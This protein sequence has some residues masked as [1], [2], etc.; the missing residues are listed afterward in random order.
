ME[1]SRVA[2]VVQVKKRHDLTTSPKSQQQHQQQRECEQPNQATARPTD[3][4]ATTL[5]C[6]LDTESWSG[7][8]DRSDAMRSDRATADADADVHESVRT[9]TGAPSRALDVVPRSAIDGL[10]NG[11]IDQH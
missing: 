9:S 6:A 3:D 8:A 4:D 2:L 11:L 7:K 1:R 5:A 10:I